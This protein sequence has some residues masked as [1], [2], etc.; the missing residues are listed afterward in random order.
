MNLDAYENQKLAPGG[1]AKR[2]VRGGRIA[3]MSDSVVTDLNGERYVF[4][5]SYHSE[6][7]AFVMTTG[8]ILVGI[9]CDIPGCGA[10]S[11]CSVTLGPGVIVYG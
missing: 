11:E 1:K 5:C 2:K 10:P 8:S 4:T 9:P 6:H 3:V 7:P